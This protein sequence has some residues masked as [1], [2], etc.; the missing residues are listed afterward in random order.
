M[1]VIIW[2][3]FVL[4]LIVSSAC[5]QDFD[6]PKWMVVRMNIEQ[7]AARHLSDFELVRSRLNYSFGRE[8]VF[9]SEYDAGTVFVQIGL[10][11][12]GKMPF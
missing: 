4:L 11:S 10:Y 6:D 3:T 2:K 7:M 5:N 8:Y 9:S 12:S 1:K